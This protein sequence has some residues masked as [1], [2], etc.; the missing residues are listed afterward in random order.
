MENERKSGKDRHPDDLTWREQD[1]L[2]LLSDRLTNREIADKL[3]L[4][5]STVKDYVSKILSKLYVKNRRQAVER[6][7]ALGLLDQGTFPAGISPGKLPLE[8]TPFVGRQEELE[9]ISQQLET[10]R[11]LTLTGPGGIGKTRLALK[12]ARLTGENYRDGCA[13]ISLSALRSAEGLVQAVAETIKFPIATQEPPLSQLLRYLRQREMLLVLDNFEHLLEGVNILNQILQDTSQI[14]LLVTSRE[15]LNLQ[16]ETVINVGGMDLSLKQ[17]AL[18]TGMTDAVI[19]FLQSASRIEPTFDPDQEELVQ[20]GRI[21]HFVGGMPLA[22][23]LAASWLHVLPLEDIYTELEI[24]LDLLTSEMRD[25]PERHRSIRAIFDHSWSMLDSEEQAIFACLSLFRGGFTWDAAREVVGA[26]LNQLSDLVNKSLVSHDSATGRLEIHELLRSFAQEKLEDIPGEFRKVSEKHG[27]YFAELM[28][29]SWVQLR[30]PQQQDTLE[31]IEADM[32]NVRSVWNYFLK[33]KN[34]FML[35]KIIYSLWY[36]YWIHWWNLP[37]MMLFREAA[38]ALEGIPGDDAKA[39]RAL[40]QTLRSYFMAWL[41]MFEE[42]YQ[43]AQESCQIMEDLGNTTGLIFSL[44]CLTLNS[45]FTYRYQEMIEINERL[46]QIVEELG[47]PWLTA[48]AL[49]AAGLA[50]I[51]NDQFDMARTYAERNLALYEEIGDSV[52]ITTPLIVLGHVAL[53]LGELDKAKGFYQRCLDLSLESQFYYSI[54]TASK[55]LAKVAL[56]QDHLEEAETHLRQSMVITNQIGFVRDI[57]NLVYE[58]ARLF[59]ARGEP[60]RAV[61]LLGLVIQHPVSDMHRMIDGRIR[62]SAEKLLGTLEEKLP[63]DVFQE[64]LEQGRSL[65]LDELTGQLLGD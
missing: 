38:T 11:L 22:I 10:T 55:Y 60:E 49:F 63:G 27:A 43:I 35:W 13:F 51:S 7:K 54:Q 28:E 32:E 12:T 21:C 30:S 5:E 31:M 39:L 4:A 46:V 48:F 34:I 58:Y 65:D 17:E 45:Y 6:A 9:Q 20:I 16:L 3:H 61:N 56:A 47:D 57:V 37:G 24:N 23:E 19:L 40:A 26:S 50:A 59:A 44:Y 33:N 36:V 41:D 2:I 29:E 25:M 42:G 8:R 64:A 53:G 62:D 1:I 14:K 15:R 52:G 18:E